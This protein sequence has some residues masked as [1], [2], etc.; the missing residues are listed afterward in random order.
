MLAECI[1]YICSA[2]LVWT[3]VLYPL[4]IGALANISPHPWKRAPFRGKAT[5][6]IAAHNEEAIIGKKL[7][8]C[9]ELDFGPCTWEVIVVSDG[10]TDATETILTET[11]SASNTLQIYMYQPRCGKAH[12]LN[13]AE[14]K[15]SGEILIFS[16]S[17]VF[18][19]PDAPKELLAPFADE[20]VGA[21][22]ARVLVRATEEKEIAGE[23][24]YMQ[25]EARVQKAEAIFYSMVGVDGALFALRRE[26]FRALSDEVIL[27]DFTLS[28]RAP[29]SDMRIVYADKARATEET[30]GSAYDEFKR[31]ARIVAGGLQF[32]RALHSMEGT[33]KPRFWF[34]L[35]SHKILRWAA[36]ILLVGLLASSFFLSGR[37]L[38]TGALAGQSIFYALAACGLLIPKLRK[39]YFFYMPFYFCTVN[40]AAI[41][42][43]LRFLTGRQTVLWEKVQR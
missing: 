32:I 16:D 11:A 31:K 25:Y 6:I 5:M 38:Y 9:L 12:A 30:T 34:M 39:N 18:L 15:A 2:G 23:S 21:V 19:E 14:K 24:L 20:R 26:L 22:C 17:N 7:Q 8:N 41:V 36:P 29:L 28:M 40:A 10:S 1:F 43:F 35:L 3:Y 13:V 4:V 37:P 33:L 27:D 42:G